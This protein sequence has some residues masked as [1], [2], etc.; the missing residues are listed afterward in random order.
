MEKLYFDHLLIGEIAHS[1]GDFPWFFGEF[2]LCLHADDQISAH[3]RRYIAFSI[4]QSDFYL[5][6]TAAVPLLDQQDK[7]L[8]EEHEFDDLINSDKW[9]I[10]DYQS[11]VINILVPVFH[12]DGSIG[13]RLA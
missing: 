2:Q 8:Q 9:N 7:L 3:I 13:W 10:I 4:R 5:N 6:Q 11:E 12:A 1:A